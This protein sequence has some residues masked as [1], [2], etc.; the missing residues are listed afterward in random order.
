VDE[1]GLPAYEYTLE[2]ESDPKA[3]FWN[4]ELKKRREHWHQVG[5]FRITALAY[6]DGYVQFLNEE[7]GLKYLNYFDEPGGNY[8]GGFGYVSDGGEIWSEAYK[9][10]PKGSVTRR[11]FGLGYFMQETEH[12]GVKVRRHTYAPYGDDPL[13]ISEVRITNSDGAPRNLVHYEYWDVNQ[14]LMPVKP[15]A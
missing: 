12:G 13:L 1:F 2:Q 4:S 5:N 8:S 9:W 15:I 7:R 6:N 3:L 11:I 10:R 14:H